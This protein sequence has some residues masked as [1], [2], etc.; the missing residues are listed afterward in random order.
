MATLFDQHLAEYNITQAQFRVLLEIYRTGGNAGVAPSTLADLL[1]I[2]RG[3]VT[4]LTSRMV[5]Q[6]WLARKPGENRRTFQLCLTEAGQAKLEDVIP[7]AISLADSVLEGAAREELRQVL[8]HLAKL[9]A[10]LRTN[11]ISPPVR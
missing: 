11:S 6:G 1:L 5:E 3:T 2:E 9:E 10:H 8:E 4:V 7:P